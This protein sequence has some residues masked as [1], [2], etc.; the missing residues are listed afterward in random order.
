[1]FNNE[2][3]YNNANFSYSNH[4]NAQCVQDWNAKRFTAG[5]E[6]VTALLHVEMCV[7]T[8]ICD[9][10][11]ESYIT[12]SCGNNTEQRLSCRLEQRSEWIEVLHKQL[13]KKS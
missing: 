6:A 12:W 1:M 8:E 11:G 13:V 2:P 9:L 10:C 4:S 7:V 3:R 5:K